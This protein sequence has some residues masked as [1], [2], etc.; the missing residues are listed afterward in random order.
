L[1][2]LLTRLALEFGF[3]FG[4]FILMMAPDPGALRTFIADVAPEGRERVA[5]ARAQAPEPAAATAT[6]IG[7]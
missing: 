4:T 5:V 3:G 7:P 1:G 6:G 2:G